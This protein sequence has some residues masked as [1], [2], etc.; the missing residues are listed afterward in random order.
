MRVVRRECACSAAGVCVYAAGVCVCAWLYRM[1]TPVHPS[2]LPFHP[3]GKLSDCS[4][5]DG[6][7]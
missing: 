2:A 5:V 1:K 4:E 6:G 3:I 7:I